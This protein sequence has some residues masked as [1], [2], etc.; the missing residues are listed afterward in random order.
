MISHLQWPKI[1]GYKYIILHNIR[2]C[3]YICLECQSWGWNLL[4]SKTLTKVA[5]AGTVPLLIL[6]IPLFFEEERQDADAAL[7]HF[8][9]W[10][11]LPLTT[12][13]STFI[14]IVACR[15]G[16][17]IVQHRG[18]CCR[19]FVSFL[20]ACLSLVLVSLM[21]IP[22]NILDKNT[23]DKGGLLI[24]PVT[25]LFWLHTY[26]TRLN[27]NEVASDLTR[28]VAGSNLEGSDVDQVNVEHVDSCDT[29]SV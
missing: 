7:K 20:L 6:Q 23:G 15:V 12:L 22:I 10:A 5:V 28:T 27:R 9:T 2:V 17:A 4:A 14:L 3:V 25:V 16:A 18:N 19:G 11:R 13:V 1:H 8:A 21:W 26:C 24:V 29:F